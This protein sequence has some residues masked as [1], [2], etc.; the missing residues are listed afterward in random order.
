MG[1]SAF[2]KDDTEFFYGRDS[3]TAIVYEAVHTRPVTVVAGPSSCGNGQVHGPYPSRR[4]DAGPMAMRPKA[5]RA[6]GPARPR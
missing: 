5:V 2:T 1:L 3:D 6:A 4:A